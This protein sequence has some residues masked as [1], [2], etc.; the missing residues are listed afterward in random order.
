ME[1]CRGSGSA[2]IPTVLICAVLNPD[3]YWECQY[4]SGEWKLTE[5]NILNLVFYISKSLFLNVVWPI[6]TSSVFFMWKNNFLSLREPDPQGYV[7]RYWF[8]S[9]DPDPNPHWDKK[10]DP[11]PMRIHNTAFKTSGKPR[12]RFGWY[13]LRQI[14][15]GP[16][17]KY[18]VRFCKCN[19]LSPSSTQPAPF[20][21]LFSH[22]M[23][24]FMQIRNRDSDPGPV[25]SFVLIPRGCAI[26]RR[27][28]SIRSS[29]WSTMT[30]R[31]MSRTTFIVQ[32]IRGDLTSCNFR[33]FLM[34]ECFLIGLQSNVNV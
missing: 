10:L 34:W 8:G 2:W 20:L 15:L 22:I 21:Y 33:G 17:L 14:F 4:G 29:T 11:D 18:L 31:L 32:V 13:K 27:L 28:L 19:H 25:S 6:T 24:N 16:V 1:Q 5:N 12:G 26:L 9:L 3:P 7:V 30:S 23:N